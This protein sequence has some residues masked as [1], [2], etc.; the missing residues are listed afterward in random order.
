MLKKLFL[1]MLSSLALQASYAQD[2]SSAQ[3]PLAKDYSL[4]PKVTVESLSAGQTQVSIETQRED[5]STQVYIVLTDRQGNQKKMIKTLSP[6]G[7][8]SNSVVGKDT[9]VPVLPITRLA[10]GADGTL[11]NAES[12]PEKSITPASEPSVTTNLIES[13]DAEEGDELASES[14]SQADDAEVDDEV[15]ADDVSSS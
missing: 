15:S 6:E 4:M 14:A 12:Q 3:V 9:N 7:E 8:E 1:I 13:E 11:V 5:G 10:I 2:A